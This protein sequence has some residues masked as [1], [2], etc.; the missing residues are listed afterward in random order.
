MNQFFIVGCIRSG[1]NFICNMFTDFVD[2]VHSD[3]E[4][5]RDLNSRKVLLGRNFAFK[6]NE[7]FNLLDDIYKMFPNCKILLVI[8][9]PREVT[10]SIYKPNPRS[11]P[12]RVFPAVKQIARTKRITEF[13]AGMSICDCYFEGVDKTIFQTKYKDIVTIVNYNDI[14]NNPQNLKDLFDKLFPDNIR[15]LNYYQQKVRKTPNQKAYLTWTPAQKENFKN[16][17]DGSLNNYLIEYGFEQSE[18]W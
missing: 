6:L 7:D 10:N 1:T 13:E 12:P 15:Q 18:D 4:Q 16:F 5:F 9:D 2:I 11:V 8:R 3:K 17:N 14:V